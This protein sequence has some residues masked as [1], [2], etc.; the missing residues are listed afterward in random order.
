MT[1]GGLRASTHELVYQRW[2]GRGVG[3]SDLLHGRA[4]SGLAQI[5]GGAEC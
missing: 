4:V 3:D 2:A 1:F 5:A